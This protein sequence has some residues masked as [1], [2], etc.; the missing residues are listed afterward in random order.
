M[1]KGKNITITVSVALVYYLLDLALRAPLRFMDNK[2]MHLVTGPNSK[3]MLYVSSGL[4]LLISLGLLV[5]VG[6]IIGVMVTEKKV[7]Y[8]IIGGIIGSLLMVVTAVINVAKLA[9][10]HHAQKATFIVVLAAICFIPIALIYV[11]AVA[12]GGWIASKRHVE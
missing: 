8:A 4:T 11:A 7:R 2:L 12:L 9:L 10:V 1:D 5:A 3:M 6:Y